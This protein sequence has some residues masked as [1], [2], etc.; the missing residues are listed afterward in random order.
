MAKQNSNKTNFSLEK[1]L[2]NFL[3]ENPEYDDF[4]IEKENDNKLF[5]CLL[6]LSKY[7]L[8]DI[9]ETAGLNDFEN[10][11]KNKLVSKLEEKILEN[12]PD[13]FNFEEP[14][15]YHL[16]KILITKYAKNDNSD[17]LIQ[18]LKDEYDE[19]IEFAFEETFE[20]C[21]ENGFIFLYQE[22]EKINF[23]IPEEIVSKSLS[24]NENNFVPGK[25]FDFAN[26][27]KI[28][29][30]LYGAYDIDLF[31][32]IYNRDF[33][34]QK[35]TDKKELK[36]L[37]GQDANSSNTF[38]IE[39]ELIVN[40]QIDDDKTLDELLYSR[41]NFKP[42]IP[43]KKELQQKDFLIDY[44]EDLKEF[45]K[46]IKFFVELK[47]DEAEPFDVVYA[48]MFFIKMFYSIKDIFTM[49]TE[50]YKIIFTEKQAK[51]FLEIYQN[52]SRKCHLWA[53]YGWTPESC[54]DETGKFKKDVYTEE[55]F[56][57]EEQA[58]LKQHPHIELPEDCVVPTE[59]EIKEKQNLF[60]SY[61]ITE[62]DSPVWQENGFEKMKRILPEIKKRASIF[63]EFEEESFGR[64]S[65]QW[66]ANLYHTNANRGGQFGNQKWNYYVFEPWEKLA[67]DLYT[68]VLADGKPIVVHSH[69]VEL[70]FEN[71]AMSVL[72]I[73]V[74]MGGWF[75]TYGPVMYWKGL[76]TKDFDE[77]CRVVAKQTFELKGLNGV[78]QFNPVPFWV[79]LKYNSILP[80]AHKGKTIIACFAQTRFI[81]GKLPEFLLD[82]SKWKHET[83]KNKKYERYVFNSE[84]YLGSSALYIEPKTGNVYFLSHSEE[85]FEKWLLKL[86]PHFDKKHYSESR[87][88]MEMQSII[89]EEKKTPNIVD[90]L[91][92]AFF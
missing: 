6:S 10:L 11:Q 78:I 85:D 30:T 58:K 2:K 7:T 35:I 23:I 87:A 50:D 71:D 54:R 37:L 62:N 72:V 47:S 22:G 45:I 42:Y 41:K 34:N 12:F 57:E 31:M 53:N 74:D 84:D 3:E 14:I 24:C 92:K 55:F 36:K 32:Q 33:P 9:A 48:V 68:C 83:S 44:D 61:W 60:D 79:A 8:Q 1:F 91:E 49:L 51:E 69:G 56:N 18:K 21:L 25:L 29:S 65:D 40:R 73:L 5:D 15:Y 89:L 81:D 52:L 38:R 77:L 17:S 59:D 86:M 70:A 64:L 82:S 88:T 75:L 46:L 26:Y 76:R 28:L 80:I 43:S 27:A 67:P 4:L 90:K 66:L 39:N 13:I 63:N 20:I 16:F 19:D